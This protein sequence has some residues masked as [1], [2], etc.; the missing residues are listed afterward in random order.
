MNEKPK[1]KY[2]IRFHTDECPPCG[3]SD[4]WKERVYDTPK[5]EDSYERYKLHWYMCSSCMMGG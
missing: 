5:P 1:R 4:T 2:W 3:R